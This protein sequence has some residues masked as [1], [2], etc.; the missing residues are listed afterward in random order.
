MENAFNTFKL[1]LSE[2]IL[3]EFLYEPD[4]LIVLQNKALARY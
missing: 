1:F 2:Y 3:R 4:A